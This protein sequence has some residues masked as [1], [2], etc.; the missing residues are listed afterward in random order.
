M[1][2][3]HGFQGIMGVGE[4]V[5]VGTPV[6]A[7]Q[8]VPFRSESFKS[9][10]NHVMDSSLAGPAAR[11]ISQQGTRI[12]EGGVEFHLR[13][14]L[15]ELILKHFFGQLDLDTPSVGINTYS[16]I[17][18]IDETSLTVAIDKNV[19][20]W[21]NAGVKLGDFTLS[22][23]PTDGVIISAEGFFVDT[24]FASVLNTTA[25]LEALAQPGPI[26]LYQ[27]MTFWI[28]DLADALS[29]ADAYC[30]SSFELSINRQLAA[31]EVNK[32]DR[33][34]ALE[35]GFRETTL[36][37]EIPRYD[38]A[39]QQFITWHRDHEQLQ[40]IITM[41]DGVNTK[42]IY[43]PNMLLM[44]FDAEFAGPE[45]PTIPVIFT[46]HPDQAGDNAFITLQDSRAEVELQES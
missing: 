14:T 43:I 16:L 36:T 29:S 11:P 33:L 39:S 8:K 30:P 10:H 40:A 15:Q 20:V 3:A 12:A 46:C 41:S 35:N 6:A 24:D 18:A 7:T 13:Y 23:S 26:G 17:P 31:T 37:I 44:E 21:E 28:G 22:G 25:S 42:A 5:T 38:T 45:F 4:E 34:E 2:T 27:D 19:A 32:Y 9:Q 1:A